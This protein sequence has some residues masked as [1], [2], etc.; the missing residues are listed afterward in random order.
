MLFIVLLSYLCSTTFYDIPVEYILNILLWLSIFKTWDN[1][2]LTLIA[3]M[4]RAFGMN[5]K[6]GGSSPLRSR[7]FLSQNVDN[8]PKAD[9]ISNVKLLQK[10]FFFFVWTAFADADVRPLDVMSCYE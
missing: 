6:V 5:P 4:V 8:F 9:N 3:Q 2:C 10:I 7:H 1:K